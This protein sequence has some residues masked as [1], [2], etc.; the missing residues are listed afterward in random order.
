MLFIHIYHLLHFLVGEFS[1]WWKLV[2]FFD[3]S[4]QFATQRLQKTLQRERA[5][6]CLPLN[7]T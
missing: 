4:S 3:K 2:T 7:L 5:A 1:G 6:I